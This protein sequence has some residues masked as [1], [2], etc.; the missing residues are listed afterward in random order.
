MMIP[1]GC[2]EMGKDGPRVKGVAFRTIDACYFELRGARCHE[3][4]RSLMMPELRA[5][6][7]GTTLLAASW[8]PI[9][10]YRDAMRSFR[11]ANND[12]LDLPRL[13]GY[14]SVRR[15]MASTYK[16]MFA[17]IVSP[18]TLLGL[19]AR[20]FGQY[21]D[22]GQFQVL[23]SRKGY[24][25]AKLSGCVGWDGNMWIEIHGSCTAFLELAGAKEVRLRTKSGGRDADEH[26]ELEGHW[27]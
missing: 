14:Q 10:W 19:S 21:Y 3:R 15:D 16:M 5:A 11:A 8:Y 12:G 17:R 1:S 27:V 22:T 7:A 23:E 4:A 6:Y 18:Q 13:I 2:V 9:A 26:L 20:L 25:H 24:V